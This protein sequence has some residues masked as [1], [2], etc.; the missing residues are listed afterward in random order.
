MKWKRDSRGT[1]SDDTGPY[2]AKEGVYYVY[3]EATSQSEGDKGVMELSLTNLNLTTHACFQFYYH[4]RGRDMGDLDIIIEEKPGSEIARWSKS[5]HISSSWNRGF[6]SI[7]AN[8]QKIKVTGKRGDGYRSDIALDDFKIF[9]E[10]CSCEP[11]KYGLVCEK[12]CDCRRSSSTSCD[13]QSGQCICQP[14]WSG[15]TCN[16][17]MVLDNCHS[18]YSFCH[19]DRC[20]CKDGIYSNGVTCSGLNDVS[21]FC[22]FDMEDSLKLC[23]IELPPLQWELTEDI[24][25]SIDDGYHL[26][27]NHYLKTRVSFYS[28]SSFYSFSIN[29]ISVDSESCLQAKYFINYEEEQMLRIQVVNE[30]T[31]LNNRLFHGKGWATAHVPLNA[32]SNLI[33]IYFIGYSFRSSPI[34]IDDIIIKTKPCVGCNPWYYGANC[35]KLAKCIRNNTSSFD[36]KG[37]CHCKKNWFGERCDCSKEENYACFRDGEV[38]KNGQCTCKEGYTRAGIGCRDID[39]CKFLCKSPTQECTNTDG[40]YTCVCKNG[41]RGDGSICSDSDLA[42]INGTSPQEG[43]LV[44][45]KQ[46]AWGALC[47]DFDLFTGITACNTMFKDI[48]GVH[49]TKRGS[50]RSANG[51]AF[52]SPQC[53]RRRTFD[54]ENCDVSYEP[55]DTERDALYLKCGACGGKYTSEFGLVEPPPQLPGNTLCSF[56]LSPTNAKTINATFITFS[57][58]S[59][60][61]SR[62]KRFYDSCQDDYIEIFDGSTKE[63]P[64]LG[65]YCDNKGRFTITSAGSSLYFIY[66]TSRDTT[67][68][69]FQ[70]IY[71]T[72]KAV[73]DPRALGEQCLVDFQCIANNA[74]CVNNICTCEVDFYKW[75]E[76][77]CAEKKAWN[78]SCYGN[79]ECKTKFCNDKLCLCPPNT[80]INGGY[81]TCLDITGKTEGQTPLPRNWMIPLLLLIFLIIALLVAAIVVFARR[82]GFCLVLRNQNAAYTYSELMST[83]NPLYG[84]TTDDKSSHRGSIISINVAGADGSHRIRLSN[85]MNVY[86]EMCGD[87]NWPE[88]EFQKILQSCPAKPTDIGSSSKNRY[89]NR[90]KAILPYDF[91]RMRESGSTSVDDYINAS[92]IEGLHS[93]YPYYIVTQYPLIT[94]QNDFWRMVWKQ[95]MSSIVNLVSN[96]EK[97]VYFPTKTGLCKSYGPI[98][99]Q[100]LSSLTVNRCTFR[101]MKITK[102]SMSHTVNHFQSSF[103]SEFTPD[104]CHDLINLI[105]LVHSNAESGTDSKPFVIHCLNGT[106]KSGVFVAMDY[107]IQLIKSGDTHVDIFNLVHTLISNREK[108]IENETQYKFL[109]DCVGYYLEQGKDN[110]TLK[111]TEDIP[112]EDEDTGLIEIS[113]TEKKTHF[114]KKI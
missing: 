64:F 40:S 101:C 17:R 9:Q 57:L 39:E 76:A 32:S 1:P 68:H 48:F 69:D 54:F 46:G 41:T 8:S 2:T 87:M 7:P 71:E 83:S 6:I 67:K 18:A 86:Q 52:T 59:R 89:K 93:H 66:R 109:F 82:K 56:L 24:G 90:N 70:I 50:Y 108:L 113:P 44:M 99:V 11:W 105:T 34:M 53:N 23:N 29:N 12:S 72:E 28:P 37:V 112:A 33:K 96:T 36:D 62:S 31:L 47:M 42:L 110:S 55:C 103:L 92:V 104:E 35:E 19:A 61:G 74:S 15:E 10:H 51:V 88:E 91:N 65:R 3:T 79:K 85:F 75:D 111:M 84:M 5:G 49:I 94:T 81:N 78:S 107:L 95:R 27:N 22:G 38:C 14:G 63:A 20:L 80:I 60:D 97:E 114:A 26:D 43:T 30:N 13:S 100:V 45:W 98:K 73:E 77:T 58:D 106:G 16:C 25:Q 21:Y 102:G 4:M